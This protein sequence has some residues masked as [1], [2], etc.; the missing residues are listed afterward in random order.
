TDETVKT[1]DA[2]SIQKEP[3]QIKF[4]NLSTTKVTETLD[5]NHKQEITW[6]LEFDGSVKKLGAGAGI[7]IHN[8]QN[9]HAEGHAYRLNV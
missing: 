7:W 2:T 4:S 3:P 6:Y 1:T 5:I 9:D 8:M